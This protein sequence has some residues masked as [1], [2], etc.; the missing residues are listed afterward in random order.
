MA[1]NRKARPDKAR[2]KKA[3]PPPKKAAKPKAKE[4]ARAKPAAR[5]PAPKAKRQ[6]RP[7]A[8]QAEPS[9]MP[10]HSVSRLAELRAQAKARRS[11]QTKAMEQ[12]EHDHQDPRLSGVDTIHAEAGKVSGRMLHY[13]QLKNPSRNQQT[14]NWFRRASHPKS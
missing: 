4:A 2:A 14:V 12:A 6:A 13:G 7:K 3:S 8:T 10:Q 11:P 9:A 5:R 1:P